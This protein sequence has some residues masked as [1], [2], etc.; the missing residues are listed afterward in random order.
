MEDVLDGFVELV[1]ELDD[2]VEPVELVEA[3]EDG[4]FMPA[5]RS[6]VSAL[7]RFRCAST[8]L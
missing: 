4:M 3:D 1:A 8:Q 2:I 5:L 6:A 7:S